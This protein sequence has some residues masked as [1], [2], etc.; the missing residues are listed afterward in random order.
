MTKN[1]HAVQQEDPLVS[2]LK[3]VFLRMKNEAL[4]NAYIPKSIRENY[5]V[6]LDFTTGTIVLSEK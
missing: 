1:V 3:H 5:K 6:R 2:A 4:K